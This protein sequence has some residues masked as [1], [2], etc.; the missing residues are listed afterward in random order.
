M[1]AM[2]ARPSVRIGVFLAMLVVVLIAA[3]GLGSLVGARLE[4]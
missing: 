2:L 3:Y 4:V 1:R